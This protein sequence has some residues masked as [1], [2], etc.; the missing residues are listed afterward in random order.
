[1]PNK[2]TPPF[3]YKHPAKSTTGHVVA[4]PMGAFSSE[5]AVSATVAQNEFGRILNNAVQGRVVVINRHN[6]PSA[7]LISSQRY[8]ELT[9][10]KADQLNLLTQQFD[11]LVRG[12]QTPAAHAAMQSAFDAST[13]LLGRAAATAK[14]ASKP[15]PKR[16]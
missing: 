15:R 8:R 6:A 3:D 14:R 2:P 9:Q 12:M 16:K 11:T 5:I 7:V 13:E 10:G 4:E 1:M